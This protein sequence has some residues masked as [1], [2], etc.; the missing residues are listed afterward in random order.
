MAW[1]R[2]MQLA[3]SETNHRLQVMSRMLRS[4]RLQFSHFV[5][6]PVNSLQTPSGLTVVKIAQMQAEKG[7]E[8]VRFTDK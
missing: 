4:E 5:I 6:C 3:L 1:V 8:A 7:L 2:E